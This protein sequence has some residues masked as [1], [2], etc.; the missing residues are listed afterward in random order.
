MHKRRTRLD[1]PSMDTSRRK[2]ILRMDKI[3]CL[4][5]IL[6]DGIEY[7]LERYLFEMKI[8]NFSIVI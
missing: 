8:L 7:R 6:F 3:D 4:R 5:L 2:V 1:F